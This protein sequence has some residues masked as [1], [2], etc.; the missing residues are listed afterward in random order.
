M[1]PRPMPI[2]FARPH[3]FLSIPA[4]LDGETEAAQSPLLADARLDPQIQ[5]GDCPSSPVAA[6]QKL[7]PS[8]GMLISAPAS[9]TAATREG[10]TPL[11]VLPQRS[12]VQPC[13][14]MKRP[15]LIATAIVLGSF[16]WIPHPRLWICVVDLLLGVN[17]CL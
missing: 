8:R 16:V 17:F 14:E 15:R 7:A 4:S 2:R 6:L 1:Q 11:F 12:F 9:W 13:R 3:V 10:G 5:S